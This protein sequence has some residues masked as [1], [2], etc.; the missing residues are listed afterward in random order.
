MGSPKEEEE[1]DDQSKPL[2]IYPD[3]RIEQTSTVWYVV[4]NHCLS[5]HRF[6]H[7][8]RYVLAYILLTTHYYVLLQPCLALPCLALPCLR[9]VIGVGVCRKYFGPS[10]PT[11]ISLLS[12]CTY[13][14]RD[15]EQK[16]KTTIIIRN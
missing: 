7:C 5:T 14:V 9:L 4:V 10:L 1:A 3:A 2:I 6:L 12:T 13:L 15:E 8:V 16:W 11:Y